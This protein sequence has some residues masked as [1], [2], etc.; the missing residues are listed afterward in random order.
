MAKALYGY[1]LGTDPRA[2]ARLEAQN[3]VLQQRVADLEAVVIRLQAENDQL[4]A[5]TSSD[6]LEPV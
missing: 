5:A 6:V 4:L 2:M 1:A 3:R